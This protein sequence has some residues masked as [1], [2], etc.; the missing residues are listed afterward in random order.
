M[1]RTKHFAPAGLAAAA[2][3]LLV[4]TFAPTASAATPP[5]SAPALGGATLSAPALMVP[6]PVPG[7]PA[8]AQA[9]TGCGAGRFV[10]CAVPAQVPGQVPVAARRALAEL[11]G[12]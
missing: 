7:E 8:A 2:A 10:D 6:V 12:D 4:A 1:N 9:W 3:G 5:L 11:L